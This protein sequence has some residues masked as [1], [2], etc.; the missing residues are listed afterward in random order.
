M[1]N[2]DSVYIVF[3]DVPSDHDK[4]ETYSIVEYDK[5]V[6]DAKAK[7]LETEFGYCNIFVKHYVAANAYNN[8][9]STRIL[10]KEHIRRA[11]CDK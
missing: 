5:Q 8:Y 9:N 1:S 3:Y 11:E 7:Y 10:A 4:L 6:A 2:Y